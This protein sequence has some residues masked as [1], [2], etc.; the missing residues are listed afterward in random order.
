MGKRSSYHSIGKLFQMLIMILLL[1]SSAGVVSNARAM[2]AFADIATTPVPILPNT[3]INT[4]T[5]TFVWSVY[6]GATAYRLAVNAPDLNS[7]MLLSAQLGSASTAETLISADCGIYV[8][9][10]TVP[11]SYCNSTECSYPSSISLPDGNYKFK[12]LAYVPSGVTPYSDFMAFSI[13]GAILPP[14]SVPPTPISP[15]GMIDIHRPAFKWSS[16]EDAT[17]YRLAVY[18]YNTYSYQLL[19]NV[20]P[21]CASG[22]CSY[23]ATSVDLPN[24]NYKFKVLARN[25]AGYTT[26]SSWMSFTVSSDL[27]IAPTLIAPSGVV[28]ANPPEFQ[29]GVVD[30][31]TKYRLAVYSYV[32][33]SYIILTNFYPSVCSGGICSYT[34]PASLVSG[35]YKFKMLTFNS[36]GYSGY[37]DWMWFSVP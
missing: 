15:T 28:G 31:A 1:V 29:W 32:T 3:T 17:F 34:P 35:N 7:S 9:L 30:G 11:L 25:S 21:T 36:Y 22:V 19:L 5:P 8:I 26:Y 18:S 10:D 13:N 33:G 20:H 16:V 14:P 2:A 24:G 37:T 27:P 6:P 12:V 23:T 4:A